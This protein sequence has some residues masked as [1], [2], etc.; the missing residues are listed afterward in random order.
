MYDRIRTEITALQDS[1]EKIRNARQVGNWSSGR[2]IPALLKVVIEQHGLL[3]RR[4]L[5]LAVESASLF[6]AQ[7]DQ[8]PHPVPPTHEPELTGEWSEVG[9]DGAF[10]FLKAVELAGY[11]DPEG[12]ITS[13][14]S[15][16]FLLVLAAV[17]LYRCGR[18]GIAAAILRR[19]DSAPPIEGFQ[20]GS[21]YAACLLSAFCRGGKDT[22]AKTR[23]LARS[24][25]ADIQYLL[26]GD[27]PTG[28]F[29]SYIVAGWLSAAALTASLESLAQFISVG[30][31]GSLPVGMQWL[32]R[33]LQLAAE[34]A[35]GELRLLL[36]SF[37]RTYQCL[38]R[39]SLHRLLPLFWPDQTLPKLAK[40]WIHHRIAEGKPFVFPGQHDAIQQWSQ[41]PQP[42]YMVSMPTGGG[43]SLLAELFVLRAT[44]DSDESS[45]KIIFVAPTRAL[46]AEK[47]DDLISGFGWQDSSIRVAQLTGDIAT[48][49][50]QAVKDF[51]VLVM[52]PEKFDTL[53]REGFYGAKIAGLIVDE[54]HAIR[55]E[56][57][58]LKLQFAVARYL[59]SYPDSRALFISAIVRRGDFQALAQWARSPD[60]FTSEWKPTPSRIGLVDLGAPPWRVEFTDGTFRR[61]ETPGP[62][63]R[64]STRQNAVKVV[65]PFLAED[66]V[67][68]FNL[69]WRGHDQDNA[70]IEL[71]NVYL[72]HLPEMPFIQKDLL[73]DLSRRFYRLAGENSGVA[74]LFGKGIALHWGLL[75]HF[76]RRLIEG[77]I[78]ERAI[79]L[80]LATSTLA[81]GVNLPIR[82]VYV[83]K[84]STRHAPLDYATFLNTI[85][86]AG[87][88]FFHSEG[89][90]IV[91][92]GSEHQHLSS[93]SEA[94][95]Y[96]AADLNHLSAIKTAAVVIAE[97]L[98]SAYQMGL[99]IRGQDEPN[100]ERN[101]IQPESSDHEPEDNPAEESST[102]GEFTDSED[103]PDSG[104]PTANAESSA[105]DSQKYINVLEAE[106]EL[107]GSVMLALL[108]EHGLG[109][110]Q[111]NPELDAA[112]F[113][114]TESPS[115]KTQVR[116][117]LKVVESRLLKH[118]AVQR[119]EAGALA[120]TPWGTQV[121]YKCGLGSGTCVRLRDELQKLSPLNGWQHIVW[122]RIIRD[123][124]VGE[125]FRLLH[126]L[127]KLPHE[128]WK[129]GS[130]PKA[131][132]DLFLLQGWVAGIATAETARSHKGVKGDFLLAYTRTEGLISTYAHWIFFACTLI[133]RYALQDGP[134]IYALERVTQAAHYG[135]TAPAVIELMK[136][137]VSR[138]LIRDDLIVLYQQVREDGIRQILAGKMSRDALIQALTS[139]PMS[140]RMPEQELA[141]ALL[142]LVARREGNSRSST[143]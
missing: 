70:L 60:P 7:R 129:M 136:R 9:T 20:S 118:G 82:T 90:V 116:D 133:A 45:G 29:D 103:E 121:V 84:L 78:R 48:D 38:P 12:E 24:I 73:E 47:R 16:S 5:A 123:G 126:G 85:G 86:R 93:E 65:H 101:Q 104:A 72:E 11:Y 55:Q 75:P 17:E 137:D 21:L 35:D 10:A 89:Q 127:L 4:G 107:L 39:L 13:H 51:D 80:I 125:R 139:S 62:V 140:T 71:G 36:E 76:A 110:F 92:Y 58:G 97:H 91:A 79:G 40:E 44:S 64:R 119:D 66:Q 32:N 115:E 57:R 96:A 108:I 124:S 120:P 132:T 27:E 143:H 52:T 41:H 117:L 56:Y 114:G 23:E 142:K 95:K 67:L 15:R 109:A 54:F 19:P 61:I 69:Y 135:H 94:R 59:R 33:S 42:S 112:L 31:E 18:H 130:E 34:S 37:H 88:P 100:S 83:P 26:K 43:K 28:E 131:L 87:R 46:A 81:E 30:D 68:H 53:L 106:I 2:P 111:N 49:A 63:D 102:S 8:P 113:I 134:L 141:D 50:E 3:V 138:E 6:Q 99:W 105:E 98:E 122:D 1:Y 25:R 77:A 74:K 128:R 22:L 14:Q